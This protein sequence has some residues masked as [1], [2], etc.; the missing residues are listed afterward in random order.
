M[1]TVSPVPEPTPRSV[2]TTT[3]P[4]TPATPDL[5]AAAPREAVI[6][7]SSSAIRC[8]LFT[9]DLPGRA[10]CLIGHPVN[11]PHLIPLVEISGAPW[12]APDA[13]DRAA[14]L[15]DEGGVGGGVLATGSVVTAAEVRMLLGAD[16]ERGADA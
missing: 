6:A 8:S 9:E 13:L 5:D 12:T 16:P 15:A 11:P 3:P 2:P 14:E 7:S 4:A 10:R 1:P